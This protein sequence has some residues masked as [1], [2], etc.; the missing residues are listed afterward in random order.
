MIFVNYLIVSRHRFSSEKEII[1]YRTDGRLTPK[2]IHLCPYAILLDWHVLWV[3][4]CFIQCQLNW[5]HFQRNNF[6]PT[7]ELVASVGTKNK[8]NVPIWD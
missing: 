7:N 3:I 6:C 5:H 2:N 4:I 8:R 1:G